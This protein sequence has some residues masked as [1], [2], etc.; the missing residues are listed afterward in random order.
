LEPGLTLKGQRPHCGFPKTTQ[1]FGPVVFALEFRRIE[2]KT[3][4]MKNRKVLSCLAVIG[5]VAVALALL[6]PPLP[7]AKSSVKRIQSVNRVSTVYVDMPGTTVPGDE[8]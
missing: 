7:K 2:W 4:S 1:C 8:N 3:F 5:L 6:L